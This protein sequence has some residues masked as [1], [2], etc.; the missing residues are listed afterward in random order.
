[1]GEDFVGELVGQP[2]KRADEAL[3]LLDEPT[4][5]GEETADEPLTLTDQPLELVW[6]LRKEN[7]AEVVRAL[8][9]QDLLDEV[10]TPWGQAEVTPSRSEAGRREVSCG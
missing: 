2:V 9:G 6:I 3:N 7:R 4:A 1:V 5:L 8:A 10:E